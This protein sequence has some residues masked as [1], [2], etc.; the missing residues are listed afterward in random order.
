LHAVYRYFE[1]DMPLQDVIREAQALD[2]GGT[3]AVLLG[4]HALRRGY[5]AT[6][7]TF[8]LKVFDP[9]W[10]AQEDGLV[11]RLKAQMEA[12]ES[13]KLQRASQAYIDFLELGGRIRMQD[14][15]AA[16]LRRYLKRSVPILTGL[17]STYLYQCAREK[18]DDWE[19][20]DIRGVP[21]GHFVVVCGYHKQH[22][23]V[24]IADPYLSNPLSEDHYYEVGLDRLVC[25]ILLGVLTYDANLLIVEPGSQAKPASAIPSHEA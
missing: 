9:T 4:C 2:E 17:S 23:T 24:R 15:N 25:A 20:D 1:D 7:F 21:T 19:P 16:L 11:P 18:E 6:I 12:K 22:R 13:V 8:N 3:L 10:F 14:L 5:R